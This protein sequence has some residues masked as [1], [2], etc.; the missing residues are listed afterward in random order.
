MSKTEWYKSWFDSPYYHI[1]YKNR[2][3][4]EAK[5][6]IHNLCENLPLNKQDNVLDL[7]CG[8][9]RHAIEL[10]KYFSYVAGIDLSHNSINIAKDHETSQLQFAVQ[11]MRSFETH[12]KFNAIFNLFTS[13]GYF[14][15]YLDNSKVLHS[16]NNALL[17]NGYIIIDYLNAHKVKM[18]I[19]ENET[20]TIDEIEFQIKR[21]IEKGKIIK[22]IFFKH[23]QIT[24]NFEEKVQLFSLNNFIYLLNETGFKLEETYGNYLLNPFD[25]ENSDRLIIIARKK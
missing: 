21:K 18:N 25:F 4:K 22:N 5:L 24:Y 2:D 6:F 19:R 20:K 12:K 1:L 11:D 8:K 17:D 7:G 9:G 10:K 13:F 14:N 3:D 16:C 23:E 15:D